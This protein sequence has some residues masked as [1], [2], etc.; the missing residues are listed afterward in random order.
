M[1]TS[2]HTSADTTERADRYDA[3]PIEQKWRKRW[4]ESGLYRTDLT[5][6][7]GRPKFY[8]LMEFPYP[9]AEG[10]HIG[11]VYTYGGADT[12][13]RFQRMRGHEVFEPMGFDAFGIHTENYALKIDTNPMQLTA[14]TTRRYRE[15]QLSRIGAMFDWTHSVDTSQPAYYRWT[16]WLFLQLYKVGLAVRKKAA[17]NWCPKDLTVLANEQV[18]DGRCERCGTLVVQRELTQWFFTITDYADRL[19]DNLEKLDWPDE[20]KR[21]QAYWI[22]RSEGAELVFAVAGPDPNTTAPVEP[23]LVFTTRPDTVFGATFVVLAPEHPLVEQITTPAQ[24][25]A[26]QAYVERVRNETEIER[27]NAEREKTGVFTGAYAINPATDVRIPI[28]ITDYVLVQYGTGATGGC[29]AHDERDYEFAHKFGLP[30]VEVVASDVGI[31]D[32]AYP[33]PGTMVNSGQFN[34]L[35]WDEAKRAIVAWLA[36]QGKAQPRVAYR[37]RDW[38]ISRQRYWGPPIPII[39]CP[40]DGIVPVPEDQLPVL[41][42]EVEDFHP[43]GTGKSPLAS[44]PSFVN[45]TCP[46]CGGPAERE[47]DVSDTFLDSSWYFL[48]YPCTEWNDRPF[49]RERLEQWLPVDMYF[50]GKEHVVMHHLYARFVTMVLH[51]MGYLPFEEPF[52]RLRLHGFVTKDGAK[53]SKSRGNVINPDEYIARIGADAFRAYM[54]F[55]GPFDQDNIFHDMNLVGVTRYVERVWRLVTE[56]APVGG[57]GVGTRP[58]HPAAQRMTRELSAYQYHTAIAALMEFGN[59]IGANRD[60]FT[61]EQYAEALRVLTLMLAPVMP[62]LAEEL[63]ER[64]GGAYSVHQQA[65]PAWDEELARES[66]IVVPVQVNGKV[67]DRLSVAPGTDEATL[68][69]Q[70]LASARV[71]E[72]LSGRAPK[73]VIVVPDRMVNIVG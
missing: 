61:I 21:R 19:L 60:A 8:N 45:T 52:T 53:M 38:L 28:W 1:T 62:F 13:G 18:I 6:A 72:Y 68:R 5:L 9:S 33:G 36:E 23:I 46:I 49:D 47:T 43:T 69:A 63:W 73:K 71:Q 70:A 51:D 25:A 56:A 42:P 3:T 12:N 40:T 39:Y 17:V 48:R 66:E 41:L 58:L 37:L 29:P 10:L 65:W 31:A 22:G 26:V 7:S 14:R 4:E 32:A 64:Q 15:E 20:S 57:G 44:V 34:G 24:R 54:L 55:M 50:G 2:N 16:Q 35:P 67:R 27:T 30:I 59:W 11:H